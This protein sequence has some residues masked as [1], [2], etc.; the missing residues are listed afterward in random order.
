MACIY[1]ENLSFFIVGKTSSLQEE[2]SPEE[3]EPRESVH[4]DQL[5]Y[6]FY[7]CQSALYGD[8][9]KRKLSNAQGES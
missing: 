1:G 4:K 2:C 7:I 5:S 6:R 8:N 3:E 9:W